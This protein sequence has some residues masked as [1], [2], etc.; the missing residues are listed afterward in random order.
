MT[1]LGTMPGWTGSAATG[2]NDRD[3]VVGT[4][5]LAQGVT[6]AFAIQPLGKPTDLGTF[7]GV[8]TQANGINA[9]GVIVGSI[10]Y[11]TGVTHAFRV[12]SGGELQDLGGLNGGNSL[13]YGLAINNAGEVVGYGGTA[14]APTAFRSMPNGTLQSLGTLPGAIKGQANAVNDYGQIVGTAIFNAGASEAF[15]FSD[16]TGMIGLT[17][18]LV[19][20][21]GW[22]LKTAT[23][24]NDFGQITGTGEYNGVTHAFLL[25]P[26]LTAVPEPSSVVLTGLGLLGLLAARGPL[27]RSPGRRAPPGDV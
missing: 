7:G 3:Q 26:V 5:T 13:S 9:T 2:I 8:S 14:A 17:Q 24:I 1:D 11:S 6:H 22:D 23:G 21:S 10:E 19:N 12:S 15:Y 4:A 25:T 27:R 16:R 18:S 20:G